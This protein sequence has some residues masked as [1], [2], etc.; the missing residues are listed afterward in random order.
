MSSRLPKPTRPL[1]AYLASL[2][3]LLGPVASFGA[4]CCSAT[5]AAASQAAPPHSCCS[6]TTKPHRPAEPQANA[7]PCCSGPSQAACTE[8]VPCAAA[9]APSG[10][11]FPIGGPCQC[12]GSCCEALAQ[13]MTADAVSAGDQRELP[14]DGA[15]LIGVP[16]AA[17]RHPISATIV[18]HR[19]KL[20]LSARALCAL[21][22]RWLN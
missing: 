7:R 1:A 14:T 8:P 10:E 13:E 15:P 9:T 12:E 11:A 19:E 21:L 22:C 5:A 3:L 6:S 17:N 18:P 16:D 20:T 2:A 4:C